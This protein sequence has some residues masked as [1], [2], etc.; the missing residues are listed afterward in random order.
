MIPMADNCNHSDV[1]VV[2]EILNKPMHLEADRE[3]KYFTKT[4]FMNDYSISYADE[5]YKDD[6]NHT[7]NVKGRF[8][9]T[10]YEANKQFTSIDKIKESLEAP[11]IQLWDVPCIREKYREDNDSEEEDNYTPLS[12]K[13]F[14]KLNSNGPL[15]KDLKTQYKLKKRGFMY[16]I[17]KEKSEL[18]R[19]VLDAK[20]AL[21]T[22][23]AT[24]ESKNQWW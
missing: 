16:L 19:K 20:E 24:E 21:K 9:K 22:S 10:N 23:G 7:L 15:V 3:G 13:D 18:K 4:K 17:D 2:Q 5:E 14:D 11:N 6:P 8:S 12:Y 1:T